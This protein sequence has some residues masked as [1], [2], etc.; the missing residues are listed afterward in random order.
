MIYMAEF[1]AIRAGGV[2][3]LMGLLG[4]N[5]YSAEHFKHFLHLSPRVVSFL[6]FFGLV[7]FIAVLPIELTM[8]GCAFNSGFNPGCVIGAG[9]IALTAGRAVLSIAVMVGAVF[10]I[11]GLIAETAVIGSINEGGDAD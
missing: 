7:G 3:T 9:L 6:V 8:A 4:L 10:S 1:T 2:A 11:I 5:W